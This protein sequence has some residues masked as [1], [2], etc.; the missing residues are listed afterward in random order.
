MDEVRLPATLRALRYRNFRLFLGGQLVSV[1]GTWMQSVAQAWLVYRLTG[2]AVLLG[3][4]SFA[5]QIPIFLLAPIG[6]IVADRFNRHRVVMATQM[7]AMLLAFVLAAL[8][9]SGTVRIWHVFVLASL[10]GIVWAF[11]IPARQSFIVNLVDEDDLMN[12]VAL[13]SSMFN[14]SRVVGPAVAGLLVASLGEGW[15]FFANG[16]SFLAV[17]LGLFL[18]KVPKPRRSRQLGSPLSDMREGF[19]FAAHHSPIRALLLLLGLI[20]AAGMPYVVL[21]PI[22]ADRVLHGGPRALGTLMGAAGIGA[23]TGA[24]LMASRNH[25]KGLP[26]WIAV[27]GLSFGAAQ[28]AFSFSR[29]YWLSLILLVV[30]GFFMMIQMVASNTLV[31]SMAPDRLRGRLISILSMA[32]IG[33]APFGALLSGI[34]ANRLGAPLTVA[35]GGLVSMTAAGVFWLH[36]PR[37]QTATRDLIQAQRMAANAS[38][39]LAAGAELEPELTA[40]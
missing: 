40:D 35:A 27:A 24:L 11:D 9:L 2:S 3:A 19:R 23:L 13:N 26:R 18:M 15:C 12:A 1:A 17:L 33:L 22:F 8:T 25:L 6:G 30:V 10:L 20:S 36:L 34:A 5:G 32:F 28:L 38:A 37:I 14:A 21:M 7:A 16:A 31:Q 4:V 39:P 29:I